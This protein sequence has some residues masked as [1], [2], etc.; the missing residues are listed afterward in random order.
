MSKLLVWNNCMLVCSVH[1]MEAK[2]KKI[3]IN[4][5][6]NGSADIWTIYA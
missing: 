3:Y 1:R 2:Q 4:I 5:H 6:E